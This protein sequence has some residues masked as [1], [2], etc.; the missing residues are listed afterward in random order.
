[1]ALDREILRT[2]SR[3]VLLDAFRKRTRSDLEVLNA[4]TMLVAPPAWASVI[5]LTPDAATLTGETEQ[6]APLLKALDASPFFQNSVFV[7]SITRS[8]G[9]EQ[10]QIRTSRR[11]RP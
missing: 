8:G 4:L 10:F 9:N 6:A 2:E 1:V 7:G 11:P 5:D 3:T